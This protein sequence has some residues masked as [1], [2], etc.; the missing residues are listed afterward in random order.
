MRLPEEDSTFTLGDVE[1]RYRLVAVAMHDGPMSGGGAT[2]GAVPARRGGQLVLGR[3]LDGR[4]G[5][6]RLEPGHELRGGDRV[7][8]CKAVEGS[9]V[10]SRCEVASR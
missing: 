9:A 8:L 10:A 3:E 1:M 5:G 6:V 2:G 7:L 4:C